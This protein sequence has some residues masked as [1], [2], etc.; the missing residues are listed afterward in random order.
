MTKKEMFVKIL[1]TVMGVGLREQA[2]DGNHPETSKMIRL[3]VPGEESQLTAGTIEEGPSGRH[4]CVR[5]MKLLT[6]AQS[7]QWLGRN[8]W[9]FLLPVPPIRK[10]Q[11]A[12][13]LTT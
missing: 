10:T 9:T 5:G 13:N 11:T 3:R 12:A 2:R 7:R 8:T 1:L 6:F 4:C